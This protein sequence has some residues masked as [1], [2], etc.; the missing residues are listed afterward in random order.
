MIKLLTGSRRTLWMAAAAC[1][2]GSFT[3]YA[4]VG[5]LA[6]SAWLISAAA[7]HPPVAELSVAIVGVRF[8]GLMRAVC[9]YLE[10]YVS[11][12]VTFRLLADIRG[13]LY[14]Q[15]EPLAPAGLMAFN[16][17][18]IFSRLVADVETLKFFYLRAVFPVLIAV[19]TAA[20]TVAFLAWLAPPLAWP[21]AGAFIAAG[22][23]IPV[24]LGR[25]GQTTG[26]KVIEARAMLNGALADSIE[27]LTELAAFGQAK[28]QAVKVTALNSRLINRQKQ[29][30]AVMA[31]ADALG[32][33]GMNIT[34]IAVI[35][36][37]A[38]LVGSGTLAGVYLA[39]AALAVQA[40]FEAILPLPAVI[41][42][43]QESKA[44]LERIKDISRQPVIAQLSGTKEILPG[45][46]HLAAH[47]LSFAYQPGL[48][49]A[50][51][52]IT[53][54]LPQ[55]KKLAIVGASGAGK[56]TLAGLILRFWD[57][58]QGA[59]LLNGDD[60]RN[61]APAA[62]RRAI[63]VVSQDTY[64]FNATIRDNILLAKPDAAETELKAAIAG[65]MLGEF[66]DK[67]PQ[68]LK[69]MT[70]QNGL[71]LSG[72]ERQRIALARAL[73]KTAP[74]WLLDEPT[75]GLDAYA[76]SI[77]MENVLQAAGSCS[78]ILITHRLIGLEAMDEILVIEG[79]KIAEQ[80]SL[81][82][83]LAQKG[84]FYQMWG[85]QQDLLNTT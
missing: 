1:M 31:M 37:A 81:A 7:L 29:A 18:D 84:V 2:L 59:L 19:V 74:V 14:T 69:T 16:K 32:T 85:L 54:N 65:A 39:V 43:W 80:G 78:V 10:R 36:L 40:S 41:Y 77:V 67:L 50:L 79:G 63:S 15:L 9:R 27:G 58:S 23:V 49:S 57:Y 44:A 5:L 12:D 75:A 22:C 33:L 56:S 17:G 55:G 71:A 46:V 76:E 82:E 60:I 73:L 83:L 28:T 61:Y 72:G 8:F 24:V 66:I 35:A 51:S 20:G 42:Y 53:F 62:V 6:A 38:P 21:V 4:N 64:L 13:W 45:A 47:N 25:L 52:G 34:V 68:G 11:H 48:P 3:I 30:N 26:R 70:G